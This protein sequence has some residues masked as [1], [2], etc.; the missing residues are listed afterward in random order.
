MLQHEETEK[1]I[2]EENAIEQI[3]MFNPEDDAE[4]EIM[5]KK[6]ILVDLDPL[7]VKWISKGN[8][9]YLEV[10]IEN[11]ATLERTEKV[12]VNSLDAE[13]TF[14]CLHNDCTYASILSER[15]PGR[16]NRIR[17]VILDGSEQI[18]SDEYEIYVGIKL[19]VLGEQPNRISIIP[20]IDNTSVR[21]VYFQHELIIFS[22]DNKILFHKK[23]EKPANEHQFK[24]K[25]R[26]LKKV[27]WDKI[28]LFPNCYTLG[29]YDRMIRHFY[30]LENLILN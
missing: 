25:E 28:V 6:R 27:D 1:D 8:P 2:G 30:A 5:S 4:I 15:L 11:V 7:A 9:R 22:S 24:I 26:L 10:Y 21:T 16:V 23:N 14:T 20:L 19:L 12:R 13:F 18:D 3:S 17:A 29:I